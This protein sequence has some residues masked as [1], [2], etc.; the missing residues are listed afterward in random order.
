MNFQMV[1]LFIP[2]PQSVFSVFSH[3]HKAARFDFSEQ[4]TLSYRLFYE[5][6]LRVFK[7]A[8]QLVLG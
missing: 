3:Y 8:D 6:L 1:K 2:L 7:K 4:Q 5:F